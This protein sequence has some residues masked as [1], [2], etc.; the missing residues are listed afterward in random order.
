MVLTSRKW[1]ILHGFNLE[2]LDFD[3]LYLS[4][5]QEQVFLW[6]LRVEALK[7]NRNGVSLTL[8]FFR[9]VKAAVWLLVVRL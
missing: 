1:I 5:L 3:G 2:I 8:L 9:L 7:V 4:C 6:P